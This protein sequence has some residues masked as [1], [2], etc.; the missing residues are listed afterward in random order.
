MS[1]DPNCKI[2]LPFDGSLVNQPSGDVISTTS[3]PVYVDAPFAQ[4]LCLDGFS[5][6]LDALNSVTSQFT[7]G[8][9]L[10]SVNPGMVTSPAGVTEPLHMPLFAKGSFATNPVTGAVT[11]TFN[12]LQVWEETHSD[13]RNVLVVKVKGVTSGTLSSSPYTTGVFHHFW[14]VYSG[15]G[16]FKIYIDLVRDTGALFTGILPGSLSVS[17]SLFSIN[18]AI[19]GQTY[20]I[21]RN[22]GVLDDLVIFDSL[23]DDPNRINRAISYGGFYTA[24]DLLSE[25]VDQ[26]VVF[27]DTAT[28]QIS[29]IYGNRGNVYAGRSDGKILK[30]ARTLWESRREFSNAD[31]LKFVSVITRSSGDNLSVQNGLLNITNAIVRV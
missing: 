11:T 4:G 6:T 10:K 19:E 26:P 15:T 9:W 29:S 27:D 1:Y 18:T 5:G 16:V 12:K 31:E 21:A 3:T 13:G 23:I 25:D 20:S 30:G 17:T 22:K 14:I 7:I 28:A 24:A 2:H 8:F